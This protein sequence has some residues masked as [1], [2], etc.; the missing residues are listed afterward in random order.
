VFH[1]A[2]RRYIYRKKYLHDYAHELY[3]FHPANIKWHFEGKCLEIPKIDCDDLKFRN[4]CNWVFR[5]D[6]ICDSYDR[7]YIFM[8][9]SYFVE[10]LKI[11]D[12]EL[13]EQIAARVG[14]EN[15]MIKIHPRNPVNRFKQAGFKTNENMSI[16]WELIVMNT[17]DI[18]DK[19]LITIASSSVMTPIL[20]FG[21]KVHVYSLYN[22]I[23]EDVKKSKLL[24]GGVWEY[25]KELFEKYNN[26]ITVC[27]SVDEIGDCREGQ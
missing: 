7:K 24:S 8:E 10:G 27:N 21:K 16:P 11:N 3:L 17:G 6:D 2:V 20:L 12:V 4:I 1:E 14:K 25:T 15:I 22:L 26:M 18:S 23:N 5:Y 19:I 13:V 9:E